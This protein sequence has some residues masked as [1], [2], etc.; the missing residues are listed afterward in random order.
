LLLAEQR[1]LLRNRPAVIVDVRTCEDRV[2]YSV[3]ELSHGGEKNGLKQGVARERAI[4]FRADRGSSVG[5]EENLL[6]EASSELGSWA[7]KIAADQSE[8]Y[9]G[10]GCAS[11]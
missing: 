8:G 6:S 11:N 5:R 1:F 10:S 2:V 7:T 3:L 9:D 4:E